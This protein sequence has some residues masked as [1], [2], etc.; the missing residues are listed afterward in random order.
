[1]DII[2]VILTSLLSVAALFI[3]TK[4]M[5]NRQ[6][7][8]LSMF[9]YINGI[10]IGSIAAE[11]ATALE[12]DFWLPLT[13][14]IV[15]AAVVV[16]ITFI[17]S[18]SLKLR[19]FFNGRTVVLFIN[20]KFRREDMKRAQIDMNEFLT[21]CRINGCFDISELECALLEPNGRMS[22]LMKA[23]SRPQK[24]SDTGIAVPDEKLQPAVILDGR[25][26]EG[27]LKAA[28]RD[29]NWLTAELSKQ[30]TAVGE[31]MLGEVASDGTLAVYKMELAKE[32]K[33]LFQ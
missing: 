6:M 3:L 22:F 7:S 16:F 2:K 1:M 12:K 14:M 30:R 13:A 21:Q 20:G 27:N 5:G 31:V 9:D 17:T 11:M 24:P 8:Q 33:D 23:D 32:R 4:L 28:G 18:K 19:R 10:T 25:V 15:Y 26:L 29:M